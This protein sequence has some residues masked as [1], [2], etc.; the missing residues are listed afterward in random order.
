MER[1]VREVGLHFTV[2]IAVNRDRQPAF[3]GA[4]DLVAAHRTAAAAAARIGAT[5]APADLLDAL[6]INAY[7]KDGELLQAEAALV[8][9]RTGMLDWLAPAAP[10]VLVCASPEGL[11]RHGLFGPGGRLFRKPAP[12]TFLK[13]RPLIVFAP[14]VPIEDARQVFWDGYPVCVSWAETVG[15]LATRLAPGARV[16]VVGC[17][18][19]QVAAEGSTA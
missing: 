10:V 18:A 13:G 14:N 4:G 6:V 7:P 11:G 1:V 12:K 16:G 2:N 15:E 17:G 8:P 9:L 5:P 3:V 19:L